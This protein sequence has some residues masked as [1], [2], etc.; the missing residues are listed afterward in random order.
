LSLKAKRVAERQLEEAS[1]CLEGYAVD[2]RNEYS[3]A[4]SPGSG[5]T[6]WAQFAVG[7]IGADSLGRI[8]KRAEEVG[9][10]S[11]RSLLHEIESQATVDR[12][13]ADQLLPWVAFLPSAQYRV[14]EITNHCLTNMFIVEKF[15]PVKFRNENGLITIS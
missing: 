11:A 8:G 3:D 15:L 6:L 7:T 9:S 10:E 2:I 12:Y 4:L 13:L 1:R 5:I 14:S